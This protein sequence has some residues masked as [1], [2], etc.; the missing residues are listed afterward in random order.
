[1]G[2]VP[3]DF[4]GEREHQGD[5]EH[6]LFPATDQ[7]VSHARA[8]EGDDAQREP[9]RARDQAVGVA[10]APEVGAAHPAGEQRREPL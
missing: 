7:A 2:E 9:A 5:V 8:G 3:D 10:T 6:G 4:N 1:M